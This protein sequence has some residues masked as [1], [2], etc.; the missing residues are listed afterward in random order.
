MLNITING[1]PAS[2]PEGSV[3]AAIINALPL[4]G[5]RF[6]VERNGEIVPK[7]QLEHTMIADG[8][9]YEIVIAVGGG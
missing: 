8:D 4:S 7:S 3:V 1:N 5:K 9:I 6:A 2:Q